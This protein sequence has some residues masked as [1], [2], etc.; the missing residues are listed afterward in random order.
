MI[1]LEVLKVWKCIPLERFS[2]QILSDMFAQM[3]SLMRILMFSIL[4]SFKWKIL[5][6]TRTLSTKPENHERKV[7][8]STENED[9][10][11]NRQNTS[12]KYIFNL[13]SA[14]RLKRLTTVHLIANIDCG[15]LKMFKKTVSQTCWNKNL[16]VTAR[17][18]LAC[19]VS[20]SYLSLSLSAALEH[21]VEMAFIFV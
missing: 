7:F 16:T 10:N 21:H 18:L 15:F 2:R 14:V 12:V 9:V 11:S 19:N 4:C 8:K 3:K 5:R 13:G 6:L 17:E 20:V 1:V